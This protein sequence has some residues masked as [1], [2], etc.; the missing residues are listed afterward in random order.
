MPMPETKVL[1]ACELSKAE[2]LS[3][4]TPFFAVNIFEVNLTHLDE[5]TAAMAKVA[6][7]YSSIP[8]LKPHARYVADD[9]Q[10]RRLVVLNLYGEGLDRNRL[11]EVVADDPTCVQDWLDALRTME[12]YEIIATHELA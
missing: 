2:L 8:G 4:E 7:H 10:R 9:G 5:F 12:R 1:A 6:E 11:Q 3:A